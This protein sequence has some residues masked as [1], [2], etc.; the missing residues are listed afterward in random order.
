MKKLLTIIVF[1]IS[2]SSFCEP[3]FLSVNIART[4]HDTSNA[5]DINYVDITFELVYGFGDN[6]YLNLVV[7]NEDSTR[8][9]LHTYTYDE[10]FG[11]VY[12][13]DGTK[14]LYFTVPDFNGNN[15]IKILHARS[16]VYVRTTTSIINPI[17]EIRKGIVQYYNI[18]GTYAGS[19]NTGEKPN[20]S[21]LFIFKIEYEDNTFASGKVYLN[22]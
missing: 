22:N 4:G 7:F 8:A 15:A 9:M 3:H 14:R 19:A 5:G 16:S 6:S 18:N 10:V 2:L 17:L 11:G 12:N 20:I 13:L 1:L 21:G